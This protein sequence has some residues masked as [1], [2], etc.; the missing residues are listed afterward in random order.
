MKLLYLTFFTLL[1]MGPVTVDPI[2]QFA[3]L[4]GKGNSHEMARFFAPTIELTL[5]DDANTYS[6]AQAEIILDKFFTLN[7]PN[8]CKML[9]KINSNVNFSFGVVIISTDKGPYRAA[10][11]LKDNDGALQLIELR[12][13]T[14]KVK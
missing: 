1:S 8:S 11:T 10:F 6:K 2:T 3:E 4:L 14:E 9:H 12:I 13:E 7:K 5:L